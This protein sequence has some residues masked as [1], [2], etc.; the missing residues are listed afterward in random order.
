MRLALSIFL[1]FSFLSPGLSGVVG[2]Q[3][4]DDRFVSNND[5]TDD[6]MVTM[7]EL[8]SATIPRLMSTQRYNSR[9]T[10][11]FGVGGTPAKGQTMPP[12][13][14]AFSPL[15]TSTSMLKGWGFDT[16]STQTAMTHVAI[17]AQLLL[18]DY[19]KSTALNLGQDPGASGE[20]AAV[21]G[22]AMTQIVGTQLLTEVGSACATC[23]ASPVNQMWSSAA[24]KNINLGPDGLVFV[25]DLTSSLGKRGVVGHTFTFNVSMSVNAVDIISSGRITSPVDVATIVA[26]ALARSTLV[27]TS[28]RRAANAVLKNGYLDMSNRR[29]R[30]T[31]RFTRILAS[32][33]TIASGV[34]TKVYAVIRKPLQADEEV[35]S[36]G[37][38]LVAVEPVPEG[39]ILVPTLPKREA[40][41]RELKAGVKALRDAKL[42]DPM[43]V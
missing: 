32:S 23:D 10:A 20:V 3:G 25:A 18:D 14:T 6:N 28:I 26:T 35:A 15:S 30:S 39:T 21:I 13:E 40:R 9:S 37:R 12:F 34:A 41:R 27:Q 29:K 5:A 31:A 8:P 42:A 38:A 2:Q 22:Y 1:S 17:T 24:S 33:S 16:T 36:R 4:D 43:V 19:T 11:T 7:D